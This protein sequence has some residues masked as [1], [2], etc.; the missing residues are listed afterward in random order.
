MQI[1]GS[2]RQKLFDTKKDALA[3]EA[4]MKADPD[5]AEPKVEPNPMTVTALD[6]ANEYLDFAKERFAFKT[7][8]EKRA[9][10]ARFLQGLPQD[11][12]AEAVTL[13]MAARFLREQSKQ[14]SGYAANKDRKNLAAAWEWGRKLL[15][16][17]KDN[18]FRE[19]DR[20]AEARKPRYIP[21]EEDFWAVYAV[22]DEQDK[23]MLLALLHTAA[24]KREIFNL[25]W[26]DLDF[27]EKRVRLW[28]RKRKGGTL[29]PDWIPMTEDLRQG[30]LRH[31]ASARSASVFY[32]PN[33]GKPY[34]HR[35]HWLKYLCGLAGVR[36]FDLHSIRHLTA[37]ILDKAGL[38]LTTIQAILRHKSATTTAR[39]LHSLRGTKAALDEVFGSGKVLPFEYKKAS[40][41]DAEG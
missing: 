16:L 21:P 19:V 20:F 7:Y 14:R 22:A 40:G 38:P 39:Y 8:D 30:L 34:K 31:R 5:W 4:K 13:P 12:L 11:T 23:L 35:Q 6:W 29:E 10:F 1:N 32:R 36:R 26:D 18:P 17:P 28:T 33:N 15:G 41:F 27:R 25:K 2:I 3:W 37:S 9:C 24:R